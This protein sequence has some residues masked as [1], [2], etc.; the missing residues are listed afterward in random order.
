[1]TLSNI[2]E[3]ARSGSIKKENEVKVEVHKQPAGQQSTNSGDP[4][5]S[6]M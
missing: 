1:V 2:A 3:F 4:K 5:R 6:M